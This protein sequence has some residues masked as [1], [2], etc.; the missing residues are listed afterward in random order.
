MQY[1][2][3]WVL[4]VETDTLLTSLCM[5][6]HSRSS[7]MMV[8][9]ILPD[10]FL[11]H[12][13]GSLLWWILQRT[14]RRLLGISSCAGLTFL[15]CLY[16]LWSLWFP[17]TLGESAGLSSA[18]P[19]VLHPANSLKTIA[20][21]VVLFICSTCDGW[22][23]ESTWLGHRMPRYLGKHYFWCAREIISRRD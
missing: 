9:S 21:A 4:M 20:W 19:P 6:D 17:Q 3:T 5:L 7:F 1:P 23:Y 10:W 2:M 14:L 16:E 11:S 15:Y 8:L 18:P 13:S 12:A 22:S